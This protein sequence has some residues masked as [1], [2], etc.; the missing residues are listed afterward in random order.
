[1]NC[2]YWISHLGS[3]SWTKWTQKWSVPK[4]L[5][6]ISKTLNSCGCFKPKGP[7]FLWYSVSLIALLCQSHDLFMHSQMAEFLPESGCQ[8]LGIHR[9]AVSLS[10]RL[11]ERRR[12]QVFVWETNEKVNSANPKDEIYETHP[13]I[14]IVSKQ[15]IRAEE[16]FLRSAGFSLG[17]RR[18]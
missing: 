9:T 7:R 2:C 17:K 12:E 11:M 5:Q 8:T 16:R 18:R 15:K 13:T 3:F 1:M 10:A 6:I 14:P 4:S